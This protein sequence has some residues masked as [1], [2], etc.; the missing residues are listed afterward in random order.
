MYFSHLM[1]CDRREGLSSQERYEQQLAEVRLLDELGYWCCWFAEHHFSGYAL[2][3]DCLL[4]AAAAARET[5][6]LRLGAGVV[7]L[8]FQH[9]PIRVVEQAAMVDCLSNGRLELGIGRGYQPHE[10]AGFGTTLEESHERFEQALLVVR[11]ALEQMDDLTYETPLFKGEHVSIWPRP[12]QHPIPCWGAAIS[13]ASFVRYGKLGWPILAFPANQPPELLRAQLDT[14][15]QAYQAHGHDPARMRLGLTMFTYV[16]AD[17]EEAHETF[18]HGMAH[19]FGYLHRITT[20]AETVQH[21]VYNSLPTTARLSGSPAQVVQRVRELC[22][23]FGITDIVNITQFRGYLTH[24]QVVGSI[25]LF[26]EQV[27]PA[28]QTVAAA[29]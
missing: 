10:F 19:Y 1:L 28:L 12:V 18:D 3:P 24:A 8:P 4:M 11:Q 17:A 27:M 21:N 13:D 29:R 7:V 16:A 23:D 22:H 6:R 5:T 14:Y 25:R 9:H 2:V 26:A 20:D 15:R